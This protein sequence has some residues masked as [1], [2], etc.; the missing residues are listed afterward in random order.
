MTD[1]KIVTLHSF[2]SF[3]LWIWV[4]RFISMSTFIW[5]PKIPAYASFS[6]PYTRFSLVHKS[7]YVV[8]V[9]SYLLSATIEGYY[10]GVPNKRAAAR[11]CSGGKNPWCTS[12][13]GT[14]HGRCKMV[15]IPRC[16]FIRGC[17][18]IRQS[19]F[20][21]NAQFGKFCWPSTNNW[22]KIEN[23]H[24]CRILMIFQK[25][26]RH[27]TGGVYQIYNIYIPEKEENFL[28]DFWSLTA[29]KLYF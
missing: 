13:L 5:H 20:N 23:L 28:K 1:L 24:V 11:A 3:M 22:Y 8:N 14:L 10:S 2:K 15:Q 16:M 26:P 12:L 29:K 9:S 27:R 25:L 19:N 17:T 4:C 7:V 6:L 21:S 18:F